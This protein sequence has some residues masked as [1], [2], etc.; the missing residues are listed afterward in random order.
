[1]QII[2]IAI[3]I[4]L[5][6]SHAAF[7]TKFI[8][9]GHEVEVEDGTYKLLVEHV[10]NIV[11][12]INEAAGITDPSEQKKISRTFIVAFAPIKDTLDKIATE[13]MQQNKIPRPSRKL[14]DYIEEAGF[15]SQIALAIVQGIADKEKMNRKVAL[16]DL[17][18]Y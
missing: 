6:L 15:R 17:S 9:F 11:N 5:I 2:K 3:L 16:Y 10:N 14:T 1:M 7:A 18:N 12:V 8:V 4:G 13:L